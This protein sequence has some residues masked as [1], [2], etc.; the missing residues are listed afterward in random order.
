MPTPL[1]RLMLALAIIFNV[2]PLAYTGILIAPGTTANS[3][4]DARMRFIAAHATLWS[5]GWVLWMVAS[6]GLVLSIWTL[7]EAMAPRVKTGRSGVSGGAL[8]RLAVVTAA[9]GGAIDLVGDGIQVAVLPKLATQQ[10]AGTTLLF[11]LADHLAS[12]LSGGAANTLY[13]VAGL[14]VLIVLARIG[15]FPRWITGLGWMAWLV[16]LGAT[17]AIFIP[18]LA[19]IVVA[20]AL[21]LYCAWL[22]AI[23]LW[24]LSAPLEWGKR[25]HLFRV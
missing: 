15:D 21:L 24:G 25:L 23:A 3:D 9:I 13:F 5:A 20:S 18:A 22:G 17:P 14:L 7:A 19:P 4:D 10:S 6:L 16:T 12:T 8:L 1:T 11:Q 2:V